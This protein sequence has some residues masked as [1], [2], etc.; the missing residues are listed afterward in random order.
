[1]KARATNKKTTLT[2]EQFAAIS[3]AL[4]DP[5]RYAILRQIAAADSMP[6]YSLAEHEVISPATISHHLKELAEAGLI[7]VEREGRIA[8]LHMCRPTFDAYLAR[9]AAL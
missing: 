4:A 7:E 1:M 5:R 6:C 9:L 2:D 8:N 3:R